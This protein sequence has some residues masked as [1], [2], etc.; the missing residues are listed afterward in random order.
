[1]P[2]VYAAVE[3]ATAGFRCSTRSCLLGRERTLG[4]L[5]VARARL[6]VSTGLRDA[7]TELSAVR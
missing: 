2:A 7:T 4:R 5:R 3:G 1:M 6:D